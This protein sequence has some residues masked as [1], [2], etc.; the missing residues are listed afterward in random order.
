VEKDE[1][2]WKIPVELMDENTDPNMIFILD[3]LVE[4]PALNCA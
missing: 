1:T 2:D 3:A 4:I